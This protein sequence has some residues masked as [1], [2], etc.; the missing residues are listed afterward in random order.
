[1]RRESAKSLG[2]KA[3]KVGTFII[4]AMTKHRLV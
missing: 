2:G 4:G 3:A 1:M